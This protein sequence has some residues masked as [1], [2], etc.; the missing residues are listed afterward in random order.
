MEAVNRSCAAARRT[1]R[2]AS[3][4]LLSAVRCG[5]TRRPQRGIGWE[6]VQYWAVQ[7]LHKNNFKHSCAHPSSWQ[8]IILPAEITGEQWVGKVYKD[9]E[10]WPSS[11]QLQIFF[12]EQIFF[13]PFKKKTLYIKSPSTQP[14]KTRRQN[15]HAGP[16]GGD[17]VYIHELRE[18]RCSD[19]KYSCKPLLT[20]GR[21]N[22]QK[23]AT[24]VSDACSWHKT[25]Q[26][27]AKWAVTSSSILHAHTDTHALWKTLV[28]MLSID[29]K[30][31]QRVD[32]WPK[33]G[34]KSSFSKIS[35]LVW[36]GRRAQAGH[37]SGAQVQADLVRAALFRHL[38][39]MQCSVKSSAASI[40]LVCLILH[41]RHINKYITM[42]FLIHYIVINVWGRGGA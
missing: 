7:L 23:A 24:D 39:V 28:K 36:T 41:L 26:V 25:K 15:K 38:H 9:A 40:L 19:A 18:C 16:V 3:A 33:H 32:E 34:G 30:R 1:V 8:V 2:P 29:L 14:N 12:F 13:P 17:R 20:N 37:R 31:H 21:Q 27:C 22:W 10:T 6:H 11:T 42:D 5:V 35:V 4:A